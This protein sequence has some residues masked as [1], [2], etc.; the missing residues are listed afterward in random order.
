M[1]KSFI[2][3]C[4]VKGH[5]LK[6]SYCKLGL[7]VCLVILSVPHS[8]TD[9]QTWWEHSSDNDTL[10][11]LFI[12]CA[13]NTLVL[14]MSACVRSLIFVRILSKLGVTIYYRS[15]EVALAI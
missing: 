6:V 14:T 1:G 3:S 11:G 4:L 10:H 12:V 15:S 2:N 9:L 8:L 5:F 7:P 13:H